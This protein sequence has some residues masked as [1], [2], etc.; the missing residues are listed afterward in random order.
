LLAY[1]KQEVDASVTFL[2]N[3]RPFLSISS[4]RLQL[5]SSED[6]W[7]A[8][9]AQA[10]ASLHP[11]SPLAPPRKSFETTLNRI[12]SGSDHDH[13]RDL[14]NLQHRYILILTLARMV[15]SWKEVLT[16]PGVQHGRLPMEHFQ[17]TKQDILTTL[18]G[19]RATMFRTSWRLQ[20]PSST[21]A[22]LQS[23]LIIHISHLYAAD[24]VMDW[25]Y[26]LI[27][28][29]HVAARWKARAAQWAAQNPVK[30]REV[31]YHSAQILAITR[32]HPSNFPTEVFATFHAGLYMWLISSLWQEQYAG[33]DLPAWENSL[34]IRLDQLD[35]EMDE[36]S[37][38]NCVAPWIIDG[39]PGA[40]PR[41]SIH[42]VPDLTGV[43]GPRQVLNLVAKLLER[44]RVWK[45]SEN[46]LQIIVGLVPHRDVPS[47]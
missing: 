40:N 28:R 32:K 25:F 35:I 13:A 15:W 7:E 38:S 46:L 8:D 33:T 41:V 34:E 36:E 21:G 42:S 43:D 39:V 27:R 9:S 10:W 44:M 22:I 23:S 1:N 19:L 31:A 16:T 26:P 17:D 14:G 5:P 3:K 2:L 47:L 6:L 45:V 12:F 20:L 30:V 18:D 37:Y 4:M 24:D 11:S 29:G